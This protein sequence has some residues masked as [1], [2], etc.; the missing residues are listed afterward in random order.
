MRNPMYFGAALAM[1]GAA[2]YYQ[3]VQLLAYAS[4]FLLF[5]HFFV[6]WYEEP[7]L[8]RTFGEDYAAY[9]KQVGRWGP[10]KLRT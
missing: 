5:F 7:T 6:I 3:S 9:R 8:H 4:A 10:K 1:A 2:L